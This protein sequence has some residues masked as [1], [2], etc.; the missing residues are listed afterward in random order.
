MSEWESG[1]YISPHMEPTVTGVVRCWLPLLLPSST[2]WGRSQ[3]ERLSVRSTNSPINHCL[4]QQMLTDPSF[5]Q[6]QQQPQHP[7]ISWLAT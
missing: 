2:V 1:G 4:Q 3:V 5:G 6:A 7:S